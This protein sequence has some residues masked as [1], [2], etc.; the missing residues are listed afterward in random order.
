MEE[1]SVVSDGHRTSSITRPRPTTAT[2]TH[3]DRDGTRF[4]DFTRP[5]STEKQLVSGSGYRLLIGVVAVVVVAALMAA[6]FVLP[7]KS[8]YRQRDD[9][10]ERERRLA[11][12]TQATTAL[13]AEVA[14][15]KTDDGIMEAAREEIGYGNPGEKRVT[16]LP[17][18]QAS[19]TLPARWPYTGVS[20]IIEVRAAEATKA[21]TPPTRAAPPAG[22]A[23]RTPVAAPTTVAGAPAP[24]VATTA[25][26]YAGPP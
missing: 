15:L 25:A 18:P 24:A 23:A 22:T 26:G 3:T 6:L 10:A 8:W 11:V 4:A 14:Y 13:K 16:V 21:T 5:I 20:Q 2:V 7:V 9:L 17:S 12:L 1:C 19:L